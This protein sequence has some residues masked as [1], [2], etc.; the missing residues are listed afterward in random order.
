MASDGS[1]R[2]V[3]LGGFGA[4]DVMS[5]ASGPRPTPGPGEVLVKVAAAGVNRPDVAQ[6]Q[7]NYP[8]PPG[9]SPIL[10]LEVAGTVAALG[11]GATGFAV[12][13]RV[14]GLANGGGYAEFCILPEGQVLP[15]PDGMDDISAAALPETFFTVWANL[16][17]MAGLEKGK[18]VLIHGG[19]SGIGT[20]AIQLA[21]AFGASTIFTTAGSAEKCAAAER[22]GAD[23]AINYR[24]K[25][26]S[27]VIKETSGGVD[28]ILDMIGG[29]YFQ[30]NLSALSR[31]GCLSIIA[32]LGGPKVEN[33]NLMPI[34]LKRLKV[35]GSTMRPR[36]DAEKREIR[37]ELLEKVW[38]LIAAGK[39]KPV[40]DRVFAFEDVVEAHRR[41]EGGDHIGKIVLSFD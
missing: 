24:E 35:T 2:H 10:G 4:P 30:R 36:T 28:I 38:P 41:M 31:D 5:I 20:T 22:L 11:E 16:F 13:D 39:V 1:M 19:T 17:M 27:E 33:A 7:G 25:D 18:S 15:A 21:K 37:D 34:M 40:I 3:A 23:V 32:F 14:C 9:A 6:R 29:A 8:P 12:G 26:F